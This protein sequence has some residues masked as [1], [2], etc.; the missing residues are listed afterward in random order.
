MGGWEE[1]AIHHCTYI[2]IPK[3]YL[4]AWV[5][6]GWVGGWVGGLEGLLCVSVL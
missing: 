1:D 5:L 4:L 3:P 2:N 6:G